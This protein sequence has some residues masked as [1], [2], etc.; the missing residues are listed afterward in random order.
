MATIL[1]QTTL[2]TL[3]RTECSRK[4]NKIA[5]VTNGMVCAA[6]LKPKLTAHSACHG[7]SGGP[8]VSRDNDGK[9]ELLGIVSWGSTTCNTTDAYT[10]F[11][12]TSSYITWIK[13]TML[14]KTNGP[15]LVHSK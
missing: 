1:Q 14:S 7:D 12:K 4:N 6:N 2:K 8:L 3:N 10:V 15:T 9:W 11:T 5:Y 13:S